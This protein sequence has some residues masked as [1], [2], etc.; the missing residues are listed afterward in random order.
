[1][2]LSGTGT[3]MNN[4]HT[5]ITEPHRNWELNR[6]YD[7]LIT[8]LTPDPLCQYAI[9]AGI[10]KP[11]QYPLL[12]AS[13]EIKWTCFAELVAIPNASCAVNVL[14]PTPPLPDSTST[15]CRTDARWSRIRCIAKHTNTTT[16]QN[17]TQLCYTHTHLTAIFPGLPRWASTRKVKP[18][19][20]L[21]K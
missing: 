20:I 2:L 10:Q 21:L 19:W 17:L 12:T 14:L 15:M 4:L 3:S 18:I 8:H 16:V 1:M 9:L 7:L 5:V 13:L 6:T 11:H